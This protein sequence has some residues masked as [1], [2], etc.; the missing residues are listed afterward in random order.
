MDN[1]FS[2][3]TVSPNISNEFKESIKLKPKKIKTKSVKD[4]N[5]A[6]FFFTFI[7]I[8]AVSLIKLLFGS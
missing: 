5:A 4:N 3:Y 8:F 6:A 7:L 2:Q 1:L